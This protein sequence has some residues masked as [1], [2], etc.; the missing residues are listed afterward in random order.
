[1]QNPWNTT[2][3]IK[4]SNNVFRDLFDGTAVWNTMGYDSNPSS[5]RQPA[6]A[7]TQ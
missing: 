1:V 2:R 5:N 7:E 6:R 4:W 3:D